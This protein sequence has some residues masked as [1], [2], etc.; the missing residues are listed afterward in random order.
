MGA[1]AYSR[2]QIAE[3][4]ALGRVIGSEAAGKQLGIQPR[5][6]RGW[7]A[8]A[9]DPPELQGDGPSWARLHSLAMARA[10]AML[11]S[12]K[13]SAVASATVAAIAQRNADK[14]TQAPEPESAVSA[15]DTFQDWICETIDLAGD[16]EPIVEA[17]EA[18]TYHGLL[19]LAN[20]EN[21]EWD[22]PY[23]QSAGTSAHRSA[24][25]A[26]HSHRPDIP[27]GDIVEWAKAQTLAVIEEHG[28][29]V[30]WHRYTEAVAH[31]E[32]VIWERGKALSTAAGLT[33]AEALRFSRE[34]LSDDLPIPRTETLR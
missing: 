32:H 10:E 29:L 8:K 14:V 22:D 34:E 16:P 23:R 28:S 9:G 19:R 6:I 24:C 3:A 31:R 2:T 27:A 5:T 15:L 26:W 21:A 18:W 7:M 4:I 11:T 17:I 33:L 25:L 12:G 20:A 30:A 1:K 13:L